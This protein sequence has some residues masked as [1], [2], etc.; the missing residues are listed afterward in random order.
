MRGRNQALRSWSTT[1]E[2][3]RNRC[4]PKLCQAQIGWANTKCEGLTVTECDHEH[5]V[6][7]TRL[8]SFLKNMTGNVVEFIIDFFILDA[9][10]YQL[11]PT[12]SQALGIAGIS[13]LIEGVCFVIS[14]LTDRGWNMIQYGRRVIDCE[15]N[16]KT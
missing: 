6:C 10:I 2:S 13:A 8:R 11:S 15:P 16:H 5:K 12:I 14:Y 3:I 1:R 7:E 9:V 4:L